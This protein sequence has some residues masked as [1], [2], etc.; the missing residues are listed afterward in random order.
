MVNRIVRF[1]TGMPI[2]DQTMAA[3]VS[4]DIAPQTAT[5]KP[6][7]RRVAN[8]GSAFTSDVASDSAIPAQNIT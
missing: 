2:T 6:C 1:G 7:S 5:R 3:R 8:H 4:R